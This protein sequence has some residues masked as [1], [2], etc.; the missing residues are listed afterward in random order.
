MVKYAA[1]ARPAI[2]KTKHGA[3]QV[4][5]KVVLIRYQILDGRSAAVAELP[6][7]TQWAWASEGQDH[8]PAQQSPHQPSSGFARDIGIRRSETGNGLG[9]G[10]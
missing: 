8:W 4:R 9:L 7:E 3:P 6:F 2:A 5:S 1:P 10:K